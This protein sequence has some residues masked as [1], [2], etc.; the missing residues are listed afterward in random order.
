MK[1]SVVTPLYNGM[2]H[3][4]KCIGSVKSQASKSISVEH[5]I[6]DGESIDNSLEFLEFYNQ[7]QLNEINNEDKYYDFNFQSS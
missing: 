3:L 7:D 5:L 6:Q 1:F 4:P 2:P